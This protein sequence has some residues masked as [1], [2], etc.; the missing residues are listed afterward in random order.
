[1]KT[2]LLIAV[3]FIANIINAQTTIGFESLTVPATGY[4]NGSTEYS[5]SGNQETIVYEDEV[6]NFH[7]NYTDTGTYDYWSAFA[8]TNQT[9]LVS[10]TY[11]NYSAYSTNGGGANSSTNYIIAYLYSADTITFDNEVTVS[12][13]DV[14][15]SV[16]AYHYMNGSD[17]SGTGTYAAGDYLDLTITGV[18]ADGTFT[19]PI[20][21]K[22]AD[23]TN[24]NTSIIGDW[25]TVDL[26]S[27][28]VIKGL[29]FQLGALDNYTPYYFCMDDIVYTSTTASVD[30]IDLENSISVYP[31]PTTNFVKISNVENSTVSIV[32][33]NG[34]KIFSRDNCSINETIDLQQ[35][36]SGVYFVSIENNTKVVTKKLIVK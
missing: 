2:K 28:G 24:G 25:T 13:I 20:V 14:T 35:I 19:N 21:F 33:I 6:A 29:K 18:L 31:N 5:G 11:T 15:N 10:A 3:L 26:S 34:K 32:D 30:N 17:G 8:Y 9:D 7:V 12:S 22:L 27:L 16:W 1:M 4:F 23:Y 36:N